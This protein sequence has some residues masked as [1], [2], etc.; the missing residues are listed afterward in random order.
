MAA[1]QVDPRYAGPNGDGS[2]SLSRESKIGNLVNGLLVAGALYLADWLGDL[3]FTPLPD[4][5]E[6]IIIA[7]AGVGIGLLTSWATQN[8]KR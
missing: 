2:Q 6:P 4:Q 5:L 1:S 8:R 3:D 7:A